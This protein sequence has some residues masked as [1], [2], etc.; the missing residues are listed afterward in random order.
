V[1]SILF[2]ATL[3]DGHGAEEESG[4]VAGCEGGIERD[5]HHSGAPKGLG[6]AKAKAAI[7]ELSR[8]VCEIS[9]SAA[10]FRIADIRTMMDDEPRPRASS[11]TRQ[12]LTVALVKPGRGACWNPPHELV[13]RHVV[14]PLRNRRGDAIE[15]QRLQFLPTRDLSD[16]NQ[17]VHSG[18]SLLGIIGSYVR[19]LPPCD[20]N[21]KARR[22]RTGSDSAFSHL[23][24][25]VY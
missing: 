21:I 10:S 17:I 7:D 3:I 6:E 9:A 18:S 15:H 11:D 8:R 13:Q 5:C 22:G 14:N 1:T 24:P 23:Q 20:G 2:E 12:V 25:G 19:T 4:K 16:C